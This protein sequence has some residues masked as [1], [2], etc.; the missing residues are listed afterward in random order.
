[1]NRTLTKYVSATA[2][3]IALS[4]GSATAAHAEHLP[5]VAAP[6]QTCDIQDS[7]C[8]RQTDNN[9]DDDNGLWGLLGLVGLFGLF[10]LVRRGPKQGAM[11]GYPAA[12]PP[13]NSYPPASPRRNPPGAQR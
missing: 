11:D 5:G 13:M 12:E 8:S 2:L 6:R 7:N 3:G 10:G 4:F 9:D 1:M